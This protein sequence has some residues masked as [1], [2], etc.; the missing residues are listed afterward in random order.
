MPPLV[1]GPDGAG[2]VLVA[3]GLLLGVEPAVPRSDVEV[4][5]E[6]GATV[7]LYTGGPVERRDEVFDAGIDA[8]QPALAELRQRPVAELSDALLAAML[9]GTRTEDDV[10]LV[11]V[12][13][14]PPA[15]LSG[16][17]SG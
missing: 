10:A 8:L 17:L 4:V 5:L 1:V 11:A 15:Q 9:P 13:L 14:R 2:R 6:P 3:P 12:R 16:Q 7:L